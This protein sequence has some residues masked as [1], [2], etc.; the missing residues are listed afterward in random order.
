MVYLNVNN[1][2]TLKEAAVLADEFSL[3]YKINPSSCNIVSDSEQEEAP[4]LAVCS[5]TL[6]KSR[7]N[8]F[9][10]LSPDHLLADCKTYN[11][12]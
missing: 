7:N 6:I 8:C 3:T 12:V 5:S 10:C 11:P 1:V 2:I 4:N 9:F